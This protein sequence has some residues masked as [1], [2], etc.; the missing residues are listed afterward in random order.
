M[1]PSLGSSILCFITSA[2]TPASHHLV[3]AALWVFSGWG[4]LRP[5]DWASLQP[6]H[7]WEFFLLRM[8]L[9]HHTQQI[10]LSFHF[11]ITTT[12]T[13][14][15]L[16][17]GRESTSARSVTCTLIALESSYVYKTVLKWAWEVAGRVIKK[18]E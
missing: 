14:L 10:L 15:G 16:F 5:G 18:E 7:F 13:Y 6:C 3:C 9:S 12:H 4:A 8:L 17:F 2:T 1:C 11:H